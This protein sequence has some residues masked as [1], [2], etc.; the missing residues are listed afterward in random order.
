[1]RTRWWQVSHFNPHTNRKLRK[2][3]LICPLWMCCFVQ[4]ST[5]RLFLSK[6][7]LFALYLMDMWNNSNVYTHNNIWRSIWSAQLTL[8]V[9]FLFMCVCFAALISFLFFLLY[10]N[11]CYSK[12]FYCFMRPAVKGS[13]LHWITLRMIESPLALITSVIAFPISPF[14]PELSLR[15]VKLQDGMKKKKNNNKIKNLSLYYGY[16]CK[17]SAICTGGRV[18]EASLLMDFVIAQL[19]SNSEWLPSQWYSFRFR[20]IKRRR[21]LNLIRE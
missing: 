5:N 9:I 21:P 14:Q 18:G 20:Q 19:P 15:A 16:I 17:R 1:M 2:P 13:P 8:S 3:A 7:F 6:H 4:S 12:S 10:S 11:T